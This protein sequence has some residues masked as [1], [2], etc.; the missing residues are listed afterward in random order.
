MIEIKP[1]TRRA[2][3]L[4][5][6]GL[7]ALGAGAGVAAVSNP[8]DFATLFSGP[9]SGPSQN[10]K[11]RQGTI[12][13]FDQNTLNNT[14]S[15]GGATLTNLPILGVAEASTLTRGSSVGVL[16][17]GDGDQ[18]KTMFIIGRSVVPG[19]DD[20][21]NAITQLGQNVVTDFVAATETTTSSSFV[22]LATIG[23]QVSINIRAS[24]KA[25]VFLGCTMANSNGGGPAAGELWGAFMNFVSIGANVLGVQPGGLG[26]Q[27]A[28]VAG[29]GPFSEYSIARMIPLSGLTPGI[30]IFRAQYAINI[31]GTS[32]IGRFRNRS[33]AVFAL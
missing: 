32:P 2:A 21:I 27:S 10:V 26:Y 5:L 28:G 23:P 18:A 11:F 1:R 14:I 4:S 19:T 17:V 24:G 31:G 16:V 25:L 6:I 8:I 30:T 29:G 13:T 12:V 15:V 22:D 9:V 3:L 33:M 7:G 20:A